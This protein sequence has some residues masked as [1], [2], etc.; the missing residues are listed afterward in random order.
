MLD[1]WIG[2]IIR[3]QGPGLDAIE[4]L[5]KG[6]IF[7]RGS[8]DLP[9]LARHTLYGSSAIS[10]EQFTAQAEVILTET[11]GRDN[12]IQALSKE[13]YWQDYVTNLSTEEVKRSIRERVE[14]VEGFFEQILAELTRLTEDAPTDESEANRRRAVIERYRSATLIRR[15]FSPSFVTALCQ[16]TQHLTREAEQRQHNEIYRIGMADIPRARAATIQAA[17]ALVLQPITTAIV[18]REIREGLIV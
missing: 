5:L 4:A 11:T 7:C 18:D 10:E 15:F 16:V 2:Q 14:E 12:V 6:R 3:P 9:I 8:L 1:Q 17:R 13:P